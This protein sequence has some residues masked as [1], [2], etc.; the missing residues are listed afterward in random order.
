MEIQF[1]YFMQ[2]FFL[3]SNNNE[4]NELTNDLG[5]IV[6][7]LQTED[8]NC[9]LHYILFFNNSFIAICPYKTALH[10]IKKIE[11]LNVCKTNICI[12][13]SKNISYL[14]QFYGVFQSYQLAPNRIIKY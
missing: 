6:K 14:K 2:C 12:L 7:G 5:I 1:H 3:V 10:S 9:E 4:I 11:K 8:F 13:Y